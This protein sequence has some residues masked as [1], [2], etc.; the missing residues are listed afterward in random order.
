MAEP[1]TRLGIFARNI[2]SN[3]AGYIVGAAVAIFLSPFVI[4]ELGTIQY[5]LWV[6]LVSMTGY[7]GLLDL[8]VRSAVGQYVTRYWAKQEIEGVNRT[9]STSF[10]LL[11]L[12]ATIAVC[13]TI[14][15]WFLLPG[16]IDQKNVAAVA[17]GDP[18]VTAEELKTLIADTKLAM[19]ISGLGIA[20][21]IPMALWATITYAKERFEIANAIGI[22]ERLAVAGFTV[23]ALFEGYGIIG[24]ALATTSSQLLAGSARIWVGFRI[25]PEL[26]VSLRRFS[27]D[28]VKELASLRHPTTLSS[29]PPTESSSTWTSSSSRRSW[30]SPPSRTTRSG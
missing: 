28:S 3:L 13:V 11:C 8:G 16:W 30:R 19:I 27:K 20:L 14:A 15:L 9:M 6:I 7:Y 2:T 17:N 23:W 12:V 21:G 24:V 4:R 25:M 22:S 10:V 5:G 1:R 29:T 18:A 26:N